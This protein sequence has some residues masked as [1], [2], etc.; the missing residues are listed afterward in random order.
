M[1]GCKR[2]E[3]LLPKPVTNKIMGSGTNPLRLA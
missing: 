1:V 3:L 2:R